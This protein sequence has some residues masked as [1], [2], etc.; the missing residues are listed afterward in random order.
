MPGQARHDEV[1]AASLATTAL[2]HLE[3]CQVCRAARTSRRREC[4]R[5]FAVTGAG[6][7]HLSGRSASNRGVVG[8][9]GILR[10]AATTQ[11]HIN[12]RVHRQRRSQLVACRTEHLCS[13]HVRLPPV[14]DMI[15][16]ATVL[17][18]C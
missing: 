4:S 1:V 15:E 16:A 5:M 17:R 2:A 8:C 6:I 13:A 3:A 18:G 7:R 12:L 11:I 9:V 14:A 10:H